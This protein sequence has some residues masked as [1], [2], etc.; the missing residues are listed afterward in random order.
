MAAMYELGFVVVPLF[1]LFFV[2]VSSKPLR[3]ETKS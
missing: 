3:R 2:F 1:L